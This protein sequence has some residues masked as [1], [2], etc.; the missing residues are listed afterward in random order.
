MPRAAPEL[1]LSV[2]SRG[3]NFRAAKC[4]VVACLL[5]VYT[6]SGASEASR[7]KGDGTKAAVSA[8][9]SSASCL[10]CHNDRMLTMRRQKREVPLF[11]DQGKMAKSAHSALECVDCHEGFDGDA[12]PHKKPMASVNCASCHEDIAAKHAFHANL[13]GPAVKAMTDV[14]CSMCHGS[15]ET[16]AVRAQQEVTGNGPIVPASRWRR[17]RPG[18]LVDAG[19]VR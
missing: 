10:E 16:I 6:W 11:V 4:F 8:A 12:M 9:N 1:F 13:A 17:S 5:G 14:T 18:G 3:A 19:A 15:H 2:G 7:T